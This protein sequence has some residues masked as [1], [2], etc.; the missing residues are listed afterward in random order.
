MPQN[1]PSA[2]TAGQGALLL[3][4]QVSFEA[5]VTRFSFDAAARTGV[6]GGAGFGAE[7]RSSRFDF[8]QQSARLL[9]LTA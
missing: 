6:F 3:I 1:G 2:L 9:A 8:S 5:S 4:Q 7:V